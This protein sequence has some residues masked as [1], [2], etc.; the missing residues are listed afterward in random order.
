MNP[1]RTIVTPPRAPFSLNHQDRIVSIGS[2]FSE[3]IGKK[4]ND[5][6]FRI[7]VNPF[8]QQYN[9][10]S[11]AIALQRL[12]QPVP[13]TES[14]LVYHN[15]LFH[16]FDHHGDFSMP[17]AELT[18]KGINQNLTQASEDL[19]RAT[20]LFLTF[21]TSHVF[22]LR[23]TGKIVSNCHKLSGSHFERGLLKPE[24]IVENLEH[25]LQ[26]LIKINSEIQVIFTVSPVRYFAFGHHENSVSKA[27]LFTAIHALQQTHPKHFY[28]P[29]YEL[30]MDDLRDYRFFSEDMLHPNY[31]ATNYV[32]Q[33]LCNTFMDKDCLQ[34]LKSIGEILQAA[35]HRPRH[36]QSLAH[37]KFVSQTIK[38]LEVLENI[39]SLDFTAERQLL[40]ANQK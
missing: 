1:Y 22:R 21:G 2:C 32:W 5:H 29:A 26:K 17:T 33:A 4:L 27:H 9:P 34:L 6:K 25:A 40:L 7:N 11:V 31:E 18:L 3:N 38:K 10:Y 16:S 14:D 13:Y 19:K 37:Q 23:E 24:E 8:G 15:E 35:R 39:H 36:S 12:L 28:F 20:K 30:V